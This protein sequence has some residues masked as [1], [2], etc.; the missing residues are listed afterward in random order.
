MPLQLFWRSPA[1]PY[2]QK[3]TPITVNAGATVSNAASLRFT[4]KGAPNYGKI[5]QE[6]LLRLLE[7]FAGDTEP[8]FPTVGQTWYDTNLGVLRVCIATAPDPVTWR[9]INA[10]QITDVGDPAPSPAAL[11][12]TWFERVGSA[13]GF[14]YVY[15]GLGRYPQVAWN[16]T[17][18][19]YFPPAATTTLALKLNTQTFAGAVGSNY[20]EAYLHGFT[21]ITA[22]DVAGTILV[23]GVATSIGPGAMFT[24]QANA[25]GFIVWDTTATLTSSPMSTVFS[26]RQLDDGTWQYD[27]N[28]TW[29][30]FTPVPGMYA[31]GTITLPE[32]D[33]N[34]APGITAATV[35]TTAVI[36]KGLTQVPAT[37]ALGAIGGWEQTHPPVDMVAGRREY[38]FMLGLVSQLIG[39][40]V[41]YGG[42]GA[43]GRAIGYLTPFHTLDASL[44][45]AWAAATPLDTG[46]LVNATHPDTSLDRLQVAPNAADWD[47]LLSAARYAVNRLEL[48]VALYQDICPFPFVQD[49]RSAV[50]DLT[51]TVGDV[52]RFPDER[53]TNGRMGS[54]T[55]HRLYQETVNVLQ[56][57][58]Q[59]RYVLKGMLGTSGTN[60]SFAAGVA[61]VLQAA[62]TA[63][64]AGSP[65][66][67]AVTHSLQLRFTTSTVDLERFF[68]SGQ[69]VELIV[70]HTPSGSPTAADTNLKAVCDTAGRVRI[71][72]DATYV[73][74][75]SATPA[76]ALTPG[77]QGW[78]SFTGGGI[79]LSTVSVGGATLTVRGIAVDSATLIVAVDVTAG[80]ATTGLVATTW[81][82]IADTETY[83]GGLDRVYP[84]P[85]AFTGTDKG[86]S[87]LFV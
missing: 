8:D 70:R 44:R 14:Q 37:Q 5:L 42:G 1:L 36:L 76:L 72:T 7:N 12:D 67:S 19:G 31:I 41:G 86:G 83:N 68:Y 26:V 2:T 61:P 66:A 69:A 28:S 52:R 35:W 85:L 9:S 62:F 27:N 10:T 22:A 38:D 29:V 39:D 51:F 63:N 33:T 3:Q 4:G 57:A 65:F 50:A 25:N 79:V 45:L 73:M 54:I 55:L 81:N 16:A 30:T 21:G 87:G 48:P 71:T 64:A 56:A 53:R 24:A 58:I 80:G 40:P 82:Y 34:V 20:S 23:N 74:D 15:T 47:R 43:I 59:S 32:K 77:A 13:S 60:P 18:A 84:T 78:S 6:N 75:S 17:T 11:G 46:V 49:G